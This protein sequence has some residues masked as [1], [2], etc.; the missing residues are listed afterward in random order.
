MNTREAVKIYSFS[1]SLIITDIQKS[2]EE[3][4]NFSIEELLDHANKYS[5]ILV[6]FNGPEFGWETA[7]QLKEWYFELSNY[8][9]ELI[10]KMTFFDK[11]YAFFRD[12]MD[13]SKCFLHDDIVR[14]VKYMIQNN[15]HDSRD[16][17][18]EAVVALDIEDFI[19]EDLNDMPVYLPELS[20]ILPEWNNSDICGGHLNYCLGE[21]LILTK[22]LGLSFNMLNEFVYE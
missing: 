2:A 18:E 22:A 16:L 3:Y 12:M 4:I 15:I 8:N 7:D 6:L 1:N 21:V 19:H 14:L 9:E 5:R 11:G 17:S 13:S 10:N 20:D